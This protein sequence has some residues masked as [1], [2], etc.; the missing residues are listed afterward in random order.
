MF[1][2]LDPAEID[3]PFE[4][5]APFEDL[6]SGLQMPV[7]PARLRDSY[8]ELI[9]EHTSTIA[10]LFSENRIDYTLV[11]TSTPLDHALFRYLSERERLSRVR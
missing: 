10:R 8:R 3:F 9:Q 2:L 5:A 4:K 11:D 6:E 1:H 7:V